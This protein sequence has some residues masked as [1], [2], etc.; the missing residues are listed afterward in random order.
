MFIAALFKI[1]KG[2][3]SLNNHQWMNGETE[4]ICICMRQG[5]TEK[6]YKEDVYT[7]IIRNLLL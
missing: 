7:Y 3:N 6:Q 1:P 2:G 4:C 5:A